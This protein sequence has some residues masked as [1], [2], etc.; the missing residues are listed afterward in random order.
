MFALALFIATQPALFA[1]VVVHPDSVVNRFVPAYAFGAGL[2]GHEHGE[3]EGIYTKKNARVMRS[4]G[5]RSLS[6]RLRTE[7][8]IEAWHWNPEGSWSDPSHK[9]GYW[10]SNPTPHRA[11]SVCYGYSLPRRGSTYDQA[12]NRGYS[13]LDDGDPTSFWKSNPYLDKTFTGESNSKH[14]QWIVIDLANKTKIDTAKIV[15]GTPYA[16][17]FRFEYWD[18]GPR[19]DEVDPQKGAWRTFPAGKVAQGHGGTEWVS[20]SKAPVSAQ[21]IRLWLTEGSGTSAAGSHDVRDRLGFAIRELSIGFHNSDGKF[22]DVINHKRDSSQT[23]MVVS[24]TDPWHRATDRDRD[25]EQPGFDLIEKFGLTNGLPMLVPVPVLFGV[26]EDAANELRWLRARKYKVR[27]IEMGEEPDGE[28]TYA[29]DYGALYLQVANYLKRVDPHVV[30][31]GPCFQTTQQDFR[32]WP[33]PS[34]TP[35]LTR[36]LTYLESRK[37]MGDLGFFSFEWYPFDDVAANPVPQLLNHPQLL[38]RVIQRLMSEGLTHKIPWMITEYGYSAFAGPSEVELPGALLNADIVAGF[39]TLG[40]DVSFLYGYEPNEVIKEKSGAWGNLMVL[41]LSPRGDEPAKL[42]TYYSAWLLTHAWCGDQTK[43]HQLCRTEVVQG[44]KPWV[45]AYSVIRPDGRLALM[46]VNR[47]PDKVASVDLSLPS[48]ALTS[49]G[50]LYRYGKAQ[51]EW[52]PAREA[53]HPFRSLPPS[54]TVIGKPSTVT[55]P[56]FSLSVLILG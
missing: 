44:P 2:D 45:G 9:Q 20:L 47:S 30:L 39:L 14:P 53:G 21:Y 46:M 28:M 32:D 13:R 27:G 18:G 55:L 50:V 6:Y 49:K 4:M 10:L 52:K 7:L 23:E 40:G 11:I 35:W 38:S 12:N 42:S 31:G 19:I 5:L 26:P 33:D 37:R 3:L 8:G 56:P 43:Q 17:Q 29:E 25:V 15:W 51:Y 41:Q 1:K 36:F 24:S 22:V 16:T 34:V 54:R 48:G